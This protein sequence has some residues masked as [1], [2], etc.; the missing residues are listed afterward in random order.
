MS[1]FPDAIQAA[2]SHLDAARFCFE[3]DRE[4]LTTSE[5]YYAMY[6]AT[7]AWALQKEGEAPGTHKGMGLFIHRL[8]EDDRLDSHL[9][10][11]FHD[12]KASRERWHYEGLGPL[13][14]VEASEMVGAAEEF[15]E[16]VLRRRQSDS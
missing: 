6:H 11:H 7:R 10:D 14:T 13:P 5:V 12:A 16:E 1:S 15:V 2:Q 8:V 9:R 4:G 3:H